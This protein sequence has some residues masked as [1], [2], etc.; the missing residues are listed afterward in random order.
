M[1]I[2]GNSA[3]KEVVKLWKAAKKVVTGV[4]T[5]HIVSHSG[6]HTATGRARIMII[7]TEAP[8]GLIDELVDGHMKWG[9][10]DGRMRKRCTGHLG[11][12]YKLCVT[13][14]V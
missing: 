2:S 14:W 1:P 10:Q 13:L 5:L 8:P 7:Q 3:A 11:L 12:K 6:R 9:A 4:N